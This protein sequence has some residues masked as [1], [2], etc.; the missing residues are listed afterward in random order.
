MSARVRQEPISGDDTVTSRVTPIARLEQTERQASL[1]VRA[2]SVAVPLAAVTLTIFWAIEIT[3]YNAP[4]WWAVTLLLTGV[5]TAAA[6]I[7]GLRFAEWAAVVQAIAVGAAD[8][9]IREPI[10]GSDVLA[11]TQEALSVLAE[12]GNPYS[13]QYATVSTYSS[14]SPSQFAYLPGELVY[15][16]IANWLTGDIVGIDRWAGIGIA[17]LLGVLGFVVGPG[18]AALAASL[19]AT[20]GMAAYLALDGSNDTSLTFLC[21]LAVTLLAFS[22]QWTRYERPLFLASAFVFAWAN[23]FKHFAWVFFVFVIIY[24]IVSGR[25][26]RTY[27]GVNVGVA[28]FVIL[29]FF[30]TAPK[31]FIVNVSRLGAHSVIW[32]LNLWSAI[33]S[34]TGSSNLVPNGLVVSLIDYTATAVLFIFFLRRPATSL[35]GALTQGAAVLFVLLFLADWTTLRIT[36]LAASCSW[37]PL[38]SRRGSTVCRRRCPAEPRLASSRQ[39]QEACDSRL[40]RGK[41]TSPDPLVRRLDFQHLRHST[42]RRER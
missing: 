38:H 18:R 20:F 28:A 10:L 3:D 35:A 40:G 11:A 19:Y 25:N 30:L 21:L 15:Y 32:G 36:S 23:T 31:D 42:S 1:P 33:N 8:R 22:E 2:G 16:G 5:G 17:V 41:H 39:P 9:L 34:A 6:L 26:W 37:R 27:L 7:A 13:H 24:L 29:P 14:L 12:G 4:Q